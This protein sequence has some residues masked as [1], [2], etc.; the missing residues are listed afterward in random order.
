MRLDLLSA[1]A[2]W[3]LTLVRTILGVVFYAARRT[4][5]VPRRGNRH[6][7]GYVGRYCDGKRP[8]RVVAQLVW[9]QKGPRLVCMT[10]L[11]E[12]ISE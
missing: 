3:T 2:D 9:R 4:E 1:N 5:T 10:H 7:A 6:R 12:E 8:L 11:I